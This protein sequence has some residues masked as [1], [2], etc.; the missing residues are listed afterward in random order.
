[1]KQVLTPLGGS[2]VFRS[3]FIR[4]STQPILGVLAGMLATLLIQS[5][6]ATVGLTIAL[7]AAGLID[8]RGA[9]CLV[10]GE[11]I[12]TT[13]TAQIASI[14]SNRIAKRAAFAHTMFNVI[15][16]AGLTV[17]MYT[18]DFYVRLVESTS[19]DIM[20]Q[21]ANSHTLFNVINAVIFLPLVGV[22]RR[23]VERIIPA[24]E[25]DMPIEP[26]FLE[27]H[28]LDT[29]LVAL[30][31][32]K[33][34]IVRM[35][36]ISRQSVKE[37][38]LAFFE[39]DSAGFKRIHTLEEGIDNLILMGRYGQFVYNN[40]DHSIETGIRAARRALGEEVEAAPVVEDEYLEMAYKKK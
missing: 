30:Q 19:G 2:E 13:I 23:V 21:V 35:A 18:T 16:V 37:A 7:A 40:I 24:G 27:P 22:L 1:M 11:N 4:F 36:S 26:K 6:S 34:E 3:F 20:R 33:S 32:V 17:V 25:A 39:G 9:I 5:S 38:T 12:G 8:I 31:Q 14:G 15:G 10:L 28:L 29:P